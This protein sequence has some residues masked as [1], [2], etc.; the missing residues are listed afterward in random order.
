MAKTQLK[1]QVERIGQNTRLLTPYN[2]GL[3]AFAHPLAGPNTYREVGAQILKQKQLIPT[4]G[5]T[6]SLIHASYTPEVENKPEFE[7]VRQ[8]MR[9]RYFWVF[10]GNLWTSKGVYVLPDDKAI[11]LSKPLNQKTLEKMLKGGKDVKGVRFSSDKR[12]RFAPKGSYKDGEQTSE[13]FAKNGFMI[14]SNGIDGAEKYGELSFNKKYFKFNPRIWIV[15]V[16]E[17]GETIQTVSAVGVYLG[18]GL[19]FGGDCHVD[20]RDGCAFGVLK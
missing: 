19:F 10:N 14:A 16:A 1:P 12:L 9:N 13:E 6:A 20:Y 7:N 18:D 4:G 5:Q 2:R 17:N 8:T 15:N 11:G 3:I